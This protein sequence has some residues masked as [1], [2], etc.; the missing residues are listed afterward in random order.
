MRLTTYA[1][2][3]LA[4]VSS[5]AAQTNP[6]PTIV[7]TI[8]AGAGTGHGLWVIDKQPLQVLGTNPAEYGRRY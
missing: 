3:A 7:L 6:Q 1:F 8:F 2:L 5:A 4:G